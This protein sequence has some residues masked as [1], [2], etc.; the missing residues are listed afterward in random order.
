MGP[1]QPP[2]RTNGTGGKVRPE[3]AAEHT[4]ASTVMED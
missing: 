2:V 4:P 3:C 1:T